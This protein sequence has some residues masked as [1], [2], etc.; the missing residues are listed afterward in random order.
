MV[1]V[2]VVVVMMV[3]VFLSRRQ[4]FHM[5]MRPLRMRILTALRCV[6]SIYRSN[7]NC[8]ALGPLAGA[9]CPGEQ[10]QS[11]STRPQTPSSLHDLAD[12]H[13]LARHHQLVDYKVRSSR[14][15]SSR[16]E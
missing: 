9:I 11:H 10:A 15:E 2:M 8:V 16:D 7:D 13:R 3:V 14:V 6:R 1:M 5:Y 4:H 12:C